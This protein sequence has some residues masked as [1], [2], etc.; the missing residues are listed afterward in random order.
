MINKENKENNDNTFG[1]CLPDKFLFFKIVFKN[2]KNII[3]VF[4]ENCYY[5]CNVSVFCGFCIL[6]VF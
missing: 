5:F 2:T 3:L 1:A 6:C 4:S